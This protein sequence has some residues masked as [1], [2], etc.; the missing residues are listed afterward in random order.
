MK[1]SSTYTEGRLSRR[2]WFV[3]GAPILVLTVLL[4]A[5]AT[6]FVSDFARKKNADYVATSQRFIT[7]ALEGRAAALRDITLD[8]ANW[9]AAYAA[10][11]Y[12]WNNAWL[13]S[14]YYSSVIDAFVVFRAGQLRY[15]WA[16]D[17]L[18]PHRGAL[19]RDAMGTARRI[20]NLD[21]LAGAPSR[22]EETV[23]AAMAFEG[24]LALL[25]VAP[26]TVEDDARRIASARANSPQDFLLSVKVLDAGEITALGQSLGLADLRFETAAGGLAPEQIAWPI[27]AMNG[28]GPARLVW[29]N[30]RPGDALLHA[31]WPI[32][33]ALFAFG[34][35]AIWAVHA[36]AMRQIAALAG[37]GAAGQQ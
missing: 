29:R 34:V 12:R 14:N 2:L 32:I 6:W 30:T 11:T 10:V 16:A 3:A 7:S 5:L 15:F 8:Y 26:I 35:C 27:A 31:I 1:H 9:D 25:A 20:P 37:P 4:A 36:L 33:V 18:T 24:K 13:A 17:Q 22:Q 28:E 21:R 19:A 23:S